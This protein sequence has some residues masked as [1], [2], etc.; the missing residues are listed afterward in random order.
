MQMGEKRRV[1]RARGNKGEVGI[2]Q[3]QSC[4]W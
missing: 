2:N 3:D 4:V 1:V